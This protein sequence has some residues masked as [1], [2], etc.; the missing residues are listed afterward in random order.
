[1]NEDSPLFKEFLDAYYV[2]Q[3][4]KTGTMVAARLP[5]LKD[6]KEYNNELFASA[7][8]PSL[9]AVDLTAFDTDIVVSHT[10]GFPDRDGLIRIDNEIIYYK[11]KSAQ[12]FSGCSRAFSA[13]TNILEN[14]ADKYVQSEIAPHSAGSPVLNL[15]LVFYGELF[16]K[17]IM[18]TLLSN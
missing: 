6:L 12:G 2:S 8:V 13:I 1:M 3:E 4:H 11:T 10:I 18:P 16:K 17:F 14:S 7:L 15:S 5:E 9:L